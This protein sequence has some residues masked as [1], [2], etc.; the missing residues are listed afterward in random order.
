M[1]HIEVVAILVVNHIFCL[2]SESSSPTKSAE[3]KEK[4]KDA[5]AEII[6][7]IPQDEDDHLDLTL[8]EEAS[9]LQEYQTLLHSIL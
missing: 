7:D 2:F 9:F 8:E 1:V 4:E 6:P 5:I 3:E